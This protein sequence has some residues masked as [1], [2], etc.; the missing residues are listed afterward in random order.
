MTRTTDFALAAFRERW[1]HHYAIGDPSWDTFERE[2]GNPIYTGHDTY[3]WPVNGFLFRDPPADR[4]YAYVG[5]YPRGYWPAGPCLALRER[6]AG[7]WEELGLAISGDASDFD[8]D[9]THPGA[10]PDVSVVYADGRYHMVYDWGNPDNTRGGLAYAWSHEP[11]GPFTRAP[12]PI[13]EDT[14][15]PP[16]LDRY[17][18]A[19]AA[20]L[21]QREHDWLVLHDMSTPGN[22]GGTWA[23]AG[24]TAPR[25]E[26]PY[27]SP[28]LLLYPQSDRFLP[29]L[30]EYYPAFAHDGYVYA[31]ATSVALNRNFQCVFRAPIERAHL[32][33]AWEI[34]Q[35][36]SVWHAEPCAAEAQGI[37]GQTFSAQVDPGGELR[38]YFTSKTRDD[39]GT[40]H[41]ARR[42]WAQPYRDGFVLSAPNAPAIAVLR[43]QYAA[44]RL[45]AQV[46]CTGN[47]ALAW[48]C[49]GPLGPS[50][51]AWNPAPHPL[52]RTRRVEFRRNRSRWQLVEIGADGVAIEQCS[53]ELSVPL[54]GHE[55]IE[56]IESGVEVELL[57]NGLPLCRWMHAATSGRLELIAEAGAILR[58]AR[59]EVT[60]ESQPGTE[61]WLATEA[62]AGAGTGMPASPILP[63]EWKPVEDARF[64]YGTG[65]VSLTPDARAKW[66]YHGRGFRL[67][68]PRRP[69]FGECEV[70]ADGQSLARINLLSDRPQSS[71]VVY[72]HTLDEGLHAV[73]IRVA[74]GV[75]PCDVLEVEQP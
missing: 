72:E 31:P 74:S 27:T 25:P 48:H 70:I 66:N 62:L 42:P 16:L 13:H 68:M 49:R 14:Y 3:L 15:Q 40:V 26:G 32:P 30:M 52:M 28:T 10:M 71:D 65:Y 59:F 29:P 61:Q 19:Y 11:G 6:E 57:L 22:A 64:S 39:V 38:A 21:I 4:W 63:A 1:L 9:G 43:E 20:T 51:P 46:E 73:V 50:T 58:V 44:F 36:G 5:L 34:Y 7:G 23:L 35:H 8:G 69:E 67:R 56:V 18:R 53:D 60:G 24:M 55:Q 17:V 54:D 33:E 37:W 12:A 75:I 41:I 45:D 47:W 2:P